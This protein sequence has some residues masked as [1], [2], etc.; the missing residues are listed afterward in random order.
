MIGEE[1]PDTN[2][3]ELSDSD[4]L[5]KISLIMNTNLIGSRVLRGLEPR[6]HRKPF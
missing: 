3:F 1:K 4:A 2:F 6:N 5:S